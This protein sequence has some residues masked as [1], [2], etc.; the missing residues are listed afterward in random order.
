MKVY[1]LLMTLIT[2][3]GLHAEEI[4]VSQ[5]LRIDALIPKSHTPWCLAVEPALPAHFVALGEKN[6]VNPLEWLYWGPEEVVKAYLQDPASLSSPIIGVKIAAQ[7][8]QRQ[9][10]VLDEAAIR[11]RLGEGEDVTLRFGNWG[12]YPYCVVSALCQGKQAHMAYVGL[13][14]ADGAVLFLTLRTPSKDP[15]AAQALWNNFFQNTKQL[16]LP[17]FFKAHG[18]EMHPGYTIVRILDRTIKVVAERRTSDQK[19]QFAV[20]PEDGTV[21]FEYAHAFEGQMGADWHLGEPLLKITGAYVVDEGWLHQSM[22]TSV[23]IQDVEQ[24]SF[25][26]LHRKNVC[27]K[28][29]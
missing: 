14:A 6:E 1:T 10:G 23:L 28:T 2:L 21:T 4:D 25:V 3:Q 16:P 29:L 26:P 13:N 24:F 18:Q 8:A 22:T 9:P 15:S 5:P 11:Q 12:A 20:I 17:L 19:I 27:V 7:F